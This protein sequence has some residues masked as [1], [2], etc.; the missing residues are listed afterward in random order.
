M[1]N[2][3]CEKGMSGKEI[4]KCGIWKKERRYEI[5]KKIKGIENEKPPAL[6]PYTTLI[7]YGD[8]SC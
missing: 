2:I 6:P 8:S 5:E 7:S 3:V 4:K 1:S